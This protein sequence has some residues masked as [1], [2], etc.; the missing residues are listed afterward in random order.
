ME[1]FSESRTDLTSILERWKFPLKMIENYNK[2]GI[3][4]IFDWQADVLG[5]EEISG[6]PS[7]RP[8]HA[9]ALFESFLVVSRV[10]K[11]LGLFGADVSWQ[12]TGR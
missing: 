5:N 6:R 9:R 10:E 11:E 1:E 3:R 2:I 12:I 8:F 4:Q 7:K